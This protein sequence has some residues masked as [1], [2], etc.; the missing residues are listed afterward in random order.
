MTL[1]EMLVVLAIFAVAAGAVALGIG[2]ASRGPN[3]EAE[4]RRL[5]A[6]IQLAADDMMVSDRPLAIQWDAKSYRLLA[7]KD[8]AW[9]GT[10]ESYS[11]PIGL[12]LDP[13]AGPAPLGADQPV[14]LR[15]SGATQSWLI[16]YDGLNAA[17]RPAS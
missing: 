17:A 9:R 4:A 15:L 6:R 8:G 7:W 2:T 1:V 13:G 14:A 11:L 12:R 5:A 3:V 16:S 10:V